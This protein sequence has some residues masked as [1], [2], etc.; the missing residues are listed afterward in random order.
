VSAAFTFLG[1]CLVT[2]SPVLLAILAA[3]LLPQHFMI[4]AEEHA[5]ERRYGDSYVQYTK[6]VPRYFGVL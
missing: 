3:L 4:L 1:I 6:R 2:A 5:C